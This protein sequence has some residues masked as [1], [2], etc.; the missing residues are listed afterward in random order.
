MFALSGLPLVFI[1]TCTLSTPDGAVNDHVRREPP[2]ITTGE[3]LSQTLSMSTWF[4]EKP[5]PVDLVMDE[6]TAGGRGKGTEEEWKSSEGRSLRR[7]LSS[8]NSSC[9]YVNNED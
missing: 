2:C 9:S 7:S 5:T 6:S 8:P 4:L 1:R 3:R